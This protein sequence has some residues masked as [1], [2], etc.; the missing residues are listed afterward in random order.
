M[1]ITKEVIEV[2]KSQGLRNA[3]LY[4]N[5]LLFSRLISSKEYNFNWNFLK[6]Q[7]K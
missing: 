1:K 6:T 5:R 4:N 2:L 7:S 3:Y